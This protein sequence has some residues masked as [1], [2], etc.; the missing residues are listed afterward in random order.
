MCKKLLCHRRLR[1]RN[2]YVHSA[3]VVL[4][5]MFLATY[6]GMSLWKKILSDTAYVHNLPT[7]SSSQEP[8]I[9]HFIH[10]NT[11]A[12]LPRRKRQ[13]HDATDDGDARHNN[14][15]GR[16]DDGWLEDIKGQPN[17]GRHDD[18]DWR[19]N[20]GDGRHDDGQQGDRR[21]DDCDERH[22]DAAKRRWRVTRR[23]GMTTTTGGTTIW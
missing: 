6:A 8:Q 17:D 12:H 21:H 3:E 23:R 15:D 13:L 16:D 2:E 14:G 18:G 7:S 20:G 9:E 22:D 19:H 10:A 5:Q 11:E 4:W 1:R